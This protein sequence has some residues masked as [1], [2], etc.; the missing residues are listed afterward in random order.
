MKAKLFKKI[1]LSFVIFAS[2]IFAISLNV[3]AASD[4]PTNQILYLTASV[5]ET[6]DH[7]G[8][9]YHTSS[10]D[11][12]VLYGTEVE[13]GEIVNPARVEPTSTLWSYDKLATDPDEY[14]FSERYVCKATLTDLEPKTTYYYQAVDGDVKSQVNSFESLTDDTKKKSFFFLTDIQ[15]SGSGFKNSQTLINAI[16]AKTDVDPNLVVMTGDQVDRGGIEQQWM[17]YYSYIPTISNTLQANVPGNHEYYTT[18]GGSYVSPEIYNQMT[19]NPLNG[20]EDK[21]GSSYYFMYGNI[22]FIMLDIVK[23][24]YDVKLQQ[25]WFRNVVNNNQAK[26]IIVGS[27]PGMYATGEYLSD[28]ENMR[29][30]WLAVF[31]ECQ[32]DLALNG[33]EHIYARKN[34][35]YGGT[36][37]SATA[38]EKNEALGVTYLAGGAAGLKLYTPNKSTLDD[39][40]YVDYYFNNTGCVITVD[41]NELTVQRYKASGIIDD[42]FTIYAKRPDEIISLT[43]Q[44]ILDSFNVEFNEETNSIAINWTEEL[45]GNAK[46]IHI[47]GGNFKG[48]GVDIPIVTSNLT[49]KTHKGY[50]ST[51]NYIFEITV[52]KND[53]SELTKKLN[54]ILNPDIAD[55][56]INYNLNGGINDPSN[57]TTF[58]G[59]NLPITL[60]EFL[61]EPTKEG[62]N[63]T[64]WILNNERRVTDIVDLEEPADITLTATWEYAITY[65][66]NGGTNSNLN[67]EGYL[68]KDLPKLL[69]S[70]SKEGYTF[71]GWELNGNIV[72]EIPV[73]TTGPITLVAK[74]N[75]TIC[76][77]TY[78]LDGGINH[79]SNS[80]TFNSSYLPAKL[81]DPEKEGYIFVGWSLN[82]TIIKEIPI[83]TY[84]DITLTAVWE[85]E[86]TEDEKPK[87][88]GCKKSAATLLLSIN[89]LASAVVLLRKKK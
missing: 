76:N 35:R 59:N 16:L 13:N 74:W 60:S 27:H 28:S 9:S 53:N 7:V 17:D 42:E 43:D 52:T 45:Y 82:G 10:D 4:F 57:P 33:H 51:Y 8:I 31:E 86:I 61:K 22:L 39:F 50:Y 44:E 88:K 12:Y 72:K 68:E 49:T 64:G 77:I 19:N 75:K 11:S 67:K 41:G 30:N 70:P 20:P 62:Y 21:L 87:K 40:D 48:N 23:Q 83:G 55:Y 79:K 18:S 84:E 25:E 15:S 78:N 26:W 46:N 3:K 32:V 65:E 71:I 56:N 73:D 34:I 85:K 14:G 24:G 5:G 6:Y 47:S 36:S 66:L 69:Y 29:K 2:F 80:T 1:A 89:L 81:Y 54:L 37:Y 63:F 38:G 58:K